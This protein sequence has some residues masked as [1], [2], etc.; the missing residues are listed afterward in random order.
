MPWG[1]AETASEIE[2]I[3]AESS[4]MLGGLNSVGEI[5]YTTYSELWD[6]YHDLL[7]KAYEQ[8]L[9][10]PQPKKG[11]W[12]LVQRGKN[13]DICCSNCGYQ[14][15]KE[16]AYNYTVDQIREQDIRGFLSNS[17]MNFCEN[18]G[19]KMEKEKEVSPEFI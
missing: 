17:N 11:H 3:R 6:F 19:A 16:F 15:I 9:K 12:K 8:G 10:T 2:K 13:I 18:C 7:G 1:I 5:D 4:D 14:R